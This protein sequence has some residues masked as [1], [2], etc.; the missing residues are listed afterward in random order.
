SDG[1]RKKLLNQAKLVHQIFKAAKTINE[2][3]LL[4]MPVPKIIGEALPKSGR[5]SL[6]EDLYRIVNRLSSPASVMLNSMSLK[7]ENSA[8]DTINRLETAI[9]AWK[10]KIE[11]HDNG[12]SPA[13]TS[14]SFKDPVSE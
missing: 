5:A 10:K 7:S 12:Q 14:W 4:E 1:E 13:R 3:I 6:G 2:S 11:Q 8:L 9:H